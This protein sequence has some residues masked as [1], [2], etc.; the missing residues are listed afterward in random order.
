VRRRHFGGIILTSTLI[1]IANNGLRRAS[2][3]GGDA[4]IAPTV[5]D[6]DREQEILRDRLSVFDEHVEVGVVVEKSR[7][8][9]RIT[10]S[11]SPLL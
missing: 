5:R 9:R 10:D 1:R 7:Y 8:A 6:G 11:L 4:A 2:R 3:V